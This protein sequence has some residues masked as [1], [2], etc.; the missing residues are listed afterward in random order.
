MRL[1][2]EQPI[3]IEAHDQELLDASQQF[4]TIMITGICTNKLED[5]KK[6]DEC[7]IIKPA[8]I[9]QA[10]KYKFSLADILKKNNLAIDCG[11]LFRCQVTM[12]GLA[13]LAS[14]PKLFDEFILLS[15][16]TDLE[17]KVLEGKATLSVSWTY[18]AHAMSYRL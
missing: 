11:I 16:P 15:P 1:E 3:S 14:M 13:K 5:S 17:F 8:N 6:I 10:M 4:Y 2:W 7:E 9:D 12:N 18:S